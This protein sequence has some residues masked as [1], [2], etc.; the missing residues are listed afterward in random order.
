MPTAQSCASHGGR[1]PGYA[2]SVGSRRSAAKAASTM[3]RCSSP[4]PAAGWPLVACKRSP[5]APIH[6]QRE[7]SIGAPPPRTRAERCRSSASTHAVPI[8]AARQRPPEGGNESVGRTH[9]R[10]SGTLT[11]STVAASKPHS[12]SFVGFSP[13]SLMAAPLPGA[14]PLAA[15]PATLPPPPPPPPRL[16]PRVPRVQVS[17]T[18]SDPNATLAAAATDQV[19]RGASAGSSSCERTRAA[20]ARCRSVRKPTSSARQSTDGR[21]APRSRSMVPHAHHDASSSCSS[22]AYRA[23]LPVHA[24]G[25]T[26]GVLSSTRITAPSQSTPASADRRRQGSQ[27]AKARNGAPVR[28]STTTR[29]AGCSV[30]VNSS[31]AET[32]HQKAMP[33]GTTARGAIARHARPKAAPPPPPGSHTQPERGLHSVS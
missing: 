22:R 21:A 28:G 2:G 1:N 3:L 33:E 16:V 11:T 18:M 26:G 10:R 6:V 25:S 8:V 5:P 17:A 13:S 31:D 29:L 9:A 12:V 27:R 4:E 14:T 24:V 19:A 7:V 20:R 15:A 23:L 30:S 32:A